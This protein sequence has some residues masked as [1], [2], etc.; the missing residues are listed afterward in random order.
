MPNINPSD[1]EKQN[2]EAH[3][4]LCGERHRALNLRMDNVD[5][6]MINHNEHD[7]EVHNSIKE[8]NTDLNVA[9]NLKIDNLEEKFE[10]QEQLIKTLQEVL[11]KNEA[12]MVT[13]G[14]GIIATLVAGLGY[15]I[16]KHIFV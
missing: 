7:K 4:Q 13:W 10:D 3:V 1:Y 12:R 8:R 5:Q 15:I 2:L 16:A 9:T 6:S 11:D 14:V